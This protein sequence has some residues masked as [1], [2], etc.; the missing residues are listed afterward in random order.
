MT[1]DHIVAFIA[2]LIV[3]SLLAA[4][5][6]AAIL[7]PY[8]SGV[9]GAFVAQN[10]LVPMIL[11]CLACAF[12]RTAPVACARS[13]RIKPVT[14]RTAAILLDRLGVKLLLQR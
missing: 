8:I 14:D 13:S 10:H 2:I 3:S 4:A 1:P 5:V 12:T 11:L 7:P 6:L 9:Q